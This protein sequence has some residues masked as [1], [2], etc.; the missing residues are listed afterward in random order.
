MIGNIVSHD[1]HP[2]LMDRA[3]EKGDYKSFRPS[4]QIAVES[5]KEL[6]YSYEV[7]IV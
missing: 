7:N 6:Y 1:K 4:D 5:G 3:Y 2:L